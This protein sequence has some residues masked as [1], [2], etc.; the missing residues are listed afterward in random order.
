MSRPLIELTSIAKSFAAGGAGRERTLALDHV[1]LSIAEGEFVCLLGP[2]GCG[3]STILNLVAGFEAADSGSV[4]FDGAPVRGPGPER[5]VVFQQPML[6]PWLNVID[7]ITFGP[8]LAGVSP[9]VYGP[10]AERYLR[11]VGLQGF[12]Q[13]APY[14]LSGGMRQRVALARAWLPRPKALLMDEP[15]GALDAQTR[16]VMQELLTSVWESTGTT[17]L[18]VTH[19]V[20]EAIALADRVLVMSAR[21]GRI[22]E[23]WAIPFERPRKLE[24]IVAD[25]R[26]GE[27]KRDVLK[28]V[29]HEARAAAALETTL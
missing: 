4:R 8:R 12:G 21:P 23:E 10:Q 14:Q 28:V 1:S 16:L 7:N 5:G 27:L 15:F 3:K 17:L 19:D 13:H 24:D 26:F 6:F 9:D 25:P 2:S 20:D 18:F 29:R 22:C 11:L